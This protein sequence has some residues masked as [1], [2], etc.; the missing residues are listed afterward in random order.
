MRLLS[1]DVDSEADVVVEIARVWE[2]MVKMTV[3]KD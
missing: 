1:A 2:A 3:D